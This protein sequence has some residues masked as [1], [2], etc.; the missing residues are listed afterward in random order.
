MPK[1]VDYNGVL[2]WWN[3]VKKQAEIVVVETKPVAQ[4]DVPKEVFQKLL[5]ISAEDK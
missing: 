4:K 2:Y 3:P 1:T 5:E